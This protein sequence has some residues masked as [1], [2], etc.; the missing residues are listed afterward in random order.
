MAMSNPQQQQQL[1]ID[2]KKLEEIR[3]KAEEEAKSIIQGVTQRKE[4]AARVANAGKPQDFSANVKFDDKNGVFHKVHQKFVSNMADEFKVLQ[5]VG[6]DEKTFADL[7]RNHDEKLKTQLQ[8]QFDRLTR[9][10]LTKNGRVLDIDDWKSNIEGIKRDLQRDFGAVQ[11]KVNAGLAIKQQELQKKQREEKTAEGQVRIQRELEELKTHANRLNVLRQKEEKLLDDLTAQ[12][13]LDEM[14]RIHRALDLQQARSRLNRTLAGG[15]FTNL[16][17]LADG[18][19]YDEKDLSNALDGRGF[20]QLKEGVYQNNEGTEQYQKSK[21]GFHIIPPLTWPFRWSTFKERYHNLI[22]RLAND[23]GMQELTLNFAEPHK[24]ARFEEI[25]KTL[26]CFEERKPKI[27][28]H[29]GIE[30]LNY[31]KAAGRDALGEKVTP[32]MMHDLEQ[33]IRAHNAEVKDAELKAAGDAFVAID[34]LAASRMQKRCQDEIAEYKQMQRDPAFLADLTTRADFDSKIAA[35]KAISD[36]KTVQDLEAK[37]AA[38]NLD[39]RLKAA[40]CDKIF[41]TAANERKGHPRLQNAQAESKILLDRVNELVAREKDLQSR[42]AAFEVS[43]NDQPR[44]PTYKAQADALQKLHAAIQEEVSTVKLKLEEMKAD[45]SADPA[46]AAKYNGLTAAEATEKSTLAT[47]VEANLRK[48]TPIAEN[49]N[50]ADLKKKIIQLPASVE[51]EQRLFHL[52]GQPP[53][54][55]R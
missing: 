41:G 10:E 25:L 32:P 2:E 36:V 24:Q 39:D 14:Q 23:G 19:P 34:T 45:L 30:T 44:N 29:V 54:P 20:D 5:T 4:F 8:N 38:V 49:M 40:Y 6:V 15:G 7:R 9:G 11:D 33:R 37:K 28:F 46:R 50:N 22:N 17:H 48:I 43:R 55:E 18:K 21:H 13:L 3:K 42:L 16:L 27:G 12:S 35:A 31:L 53:R 47:E 52:A 51:E 1:V 26:E